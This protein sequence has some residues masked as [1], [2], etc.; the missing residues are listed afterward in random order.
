MNSLFYNIQQIS[1]VAMNQNGTTA[2]S[3][4]TD[5]IILKLKWSL[6]TLREE[7]WSYFPSVLDMWGRM[8]QIRGDIY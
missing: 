2:L 6:K 3:L 4:Y 7:K 1:C 8:R 5:C